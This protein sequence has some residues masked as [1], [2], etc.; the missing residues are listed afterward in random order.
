MIKIRILKNKKEIYNACE[1]LHL[2]N[3]TQGGWKF[4]SDNP[5]SLRIKN[6]NFRKA[7]I[8]RFTNSAIWFGAFDEKKIIGCTRLT[9]VDENNKFEVEG[10]SNSDIIKQYLP[11]YKNFCVESTRTAIA[12][13]YS[14]QGLVRKLLLKAFQYCEKNKYSII[15]CVS[16]SYLK[17]LL[18][19]IN[20]PLKMDCA[21][22]YEENDPYPVNFY[23]A[24]YNKFEVKVMIDNLKKLSGKINI[25]Q[26][27]IFKSL[28]DIASILPCPVYWQ[29]LNGK[30]L[31]LNE[32]CLKGMGAI[33]KEDVIGKNPYNFY[34]K[35]I[36]DQIVNHNNLVIK[37]GEILSQ[38]ECIE[39]ITTKQIK[40]FRNI[41]A[42]LYNNEGVMVGI[43]GTAMDITAEIEAEHLQHEIQVYKEERRTQE[44][45]KTCIDAINNVMQSYKIN[46]VNNKLG[47]EIKNRC[48]DND[49][50]I[51][52]TKRESEVLY[53]LSLN[54]SPKEIASIVGILENKHVSP[55]TIQAIID[56]QLYFK[57]K[58]F[59]ISNL[60]EKA[61][62]LKL[63]PFLPEIIN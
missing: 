19:K 41:K 34:P 46:A 5:S 2:V 45:F 1:L 3:I 38:D 58:V 50:K 54:K 11:Q 39:N 27:I 8:D 9:F 61:Y 30:V 47:S 31:G 14:G 53:F 35:H 55:A 59:S 12:K 15:A 26:N 40:Y 57:F 42:P 25:N 18:K 33:R 51:K 7:L 37:S 49:L 36:A 63:I 29:D 20:F 4:D 28:D 13:E 22:K 60:I 10:Y 43:V 6:I 17:S 21:F 44:V 48:N 23:F 52:L 32:Q 62:L 24:D 16:N 56:K